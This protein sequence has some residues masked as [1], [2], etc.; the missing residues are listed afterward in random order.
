MGK[1]IEVVPS[2][3]WGRLTLVEEV[4]ARIDKAGIKKR[5]MRCRCDCGVEGIYLLSNLSIGSTKSCGC[6]HRENVK[7][8]TQFLWY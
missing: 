2:Q 4:E 3:R 6:I 5:Q 1:R 8:G 7:N